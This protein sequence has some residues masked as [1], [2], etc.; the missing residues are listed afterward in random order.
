MAGSELE[1]LALL[2]AK[3]VNEAAVVELIRRRYSQN[4]I[5]TA[6][7]DILLSVNPF[8]SLLIYGTQVIQAYQTSQADRQLPPH[9]YSKCK[10]ILKSMCHSSKSQCCVLTG[11]SASGK[12][13][14]LRHIL[15][16]IAKLSA[17]KIHHYM[18]EKS[19]VVHQEKGGIFHYLLYGMDA[20]QLQEY[21]L[22]SDYPHRSV[23]QST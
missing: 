3:V 11:D 7:G 9:V 17:G 15:G 2:E 20:D 10:T 4:K 5:Y 18:L 14:S 21:S 12:T 6:V 19:R 1:D 8:K 16:Y 13:E 22:T 23:N